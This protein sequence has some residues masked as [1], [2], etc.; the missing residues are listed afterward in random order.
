MRAGPHPGR[1]MHRAAGQQSLLPGRAVADA[2]A[3]RHC[4]RGLSPKEA[5]VKSV[6]NERAGG[7]PPDGMPVLSR[8]RHAGPEEGACLMEYVSVLAGEPFSDHPTCVEP[9]LI[10]LAWAVNDA[11]P[12]QVRASLV[13][14]AP[15]LAGTRNDSL[16][17]APMM[18]ATCID[19]VASNASIDEDAFLLA[20]RARAHKRLNKLAHRPA[21]RRV[22]W[23]DRWYRRWHADDVVRECVR[24]LASEAPES[25]PHLLG[26]AICS[27]EGV[28]HGSPA[29]TA[30]VAT[31]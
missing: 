8:G 26:A 29:G 1:V 31:R 15:R 16:L 4:Y 3:E 2:P 17:T 19:S 23:S 18:L 12:T 28:T 6:K 21:G 11:A 27:V 30:P 24:V 7:A 5:L 10:R 14:Y 22:E 25:L 13:L 20:A 9:L